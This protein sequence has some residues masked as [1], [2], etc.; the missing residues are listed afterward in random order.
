MC[1]ALERGGEQATQPQTEDNTDCASPAKLGNG[2]LWGQ[3]EQEGAP[4]LSGEGREGRE[5]AL[6]SGFH[7]WCQSSR[8]PLDM[9]IILFLS[10]WGLWF[11]CPMPHVTS[12]WRW[13]H[14]L[15]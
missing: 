1:P 12:P 14:G 8:M 3:W 6:Y 5:E 9:P 11:C 15:R 2:G 4:S 7:N 10:P 13:L